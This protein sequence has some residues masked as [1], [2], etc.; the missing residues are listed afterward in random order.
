MLIG[1]LLTGSAMK[2]IYIIA[3]FHVR[4][5]VATRQK[6]ILIKALRVFRGITHQQQPQRF[7]AVFNLQLRARSWNLASISAV[8]MSE[9]NFYPHT[10]VYRG[11]ISFASES[12]ARKCRLWN[13]PCGAVN[14]GITPCELYIFIDRSEVSIIQ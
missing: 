7:V 5:N 4:R 11:F 6:L 1:V 8:A 14:H 2:N 13:A 10:L 9:K 3:G 12:A